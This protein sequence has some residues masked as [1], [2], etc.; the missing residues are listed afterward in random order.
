MGD[1]RP[2]LEYLVSCSASA[3]ESIELARL[4]QA[5]NLRKEFRQLLE[6]LIDSEVD[7]R[8][9]RL[10]LECRRVQT[11]SPAGG[12]PEPAQPAR[13]EQFAMSFLP[14]PGEPGNAT[15]NG[16]RPRICG[17]QEPAHAAPV[18]APTESRTDMRRVAHAASRRRRNCRAARSAENSD[19]A[20]GPADAPASRLAP[21]AKSDAAGLRA[22]EPVAHDRASTPSC[23]APNAG[24]KHSGAQLPKLAAQDLALFHSLQRR[25]LVQQRSQNQAFLASANKRASTT[26]VSLRSASRAALGA[27]EMAPP[28]VRF[29]RLPLH[30]AVRCSAR[31]WRCRA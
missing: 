7:A 21:F 16:S 9:A 20:F 31:L 3:L 26:V 6:E 10:I 19:A 18:S 8:L 17:H 30:A 11:S 13:L 4:N 22:L 24:N 29:D 14:L 27:I 5:S 12:A 28:L 23:A 1:A 2:P 15:E 25:P